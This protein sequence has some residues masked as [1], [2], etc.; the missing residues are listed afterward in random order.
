MKRRKMKL[1][2][3]TLP[4]PLNKIP[5]SSF[6]SSTRPHFEPKITKFPNILFKMPKFCKFVVFKPK[7]AK[8]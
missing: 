2:E 3:D 7:K 8:I 5:F 1:A 4:Q 6:S